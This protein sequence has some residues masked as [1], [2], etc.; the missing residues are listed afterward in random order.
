VRSPRP[1]PPRGCAPTTVP[2]SSS[3]CFTWAEDLPE[4]RRLLRAA[5]RWAD[6]QG[7]VID[8]SAL[9]IHQIELELRAGNWQLADRLASDGP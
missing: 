2:S 9:G 1:P 6:E 7:D 8:Q 4:A 3:A 5:A